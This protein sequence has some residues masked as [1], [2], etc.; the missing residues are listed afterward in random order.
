MFVTFGHQNG[1]KINHKTPQRRHKTHHEVH[2][3]IAT[4]TYQFWEPNG[5]QNGAQMSDGWFF[6][7][8][9][10]RLGHTMA[11]KSS[12]SPP[13]PEAQNTRKCKVFN[14]KYRK[15]T[16]VREVLA[17]PLEPIP[18][19]REKQIIKINVSNIRKNTRF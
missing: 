16:K 12:P 4:H 8:V 10:E 5:S 3:K 7:R 2:D 17:P 9:R 1:S 19:K 13:P 6:G 11:S 14:S 18:T 15:H